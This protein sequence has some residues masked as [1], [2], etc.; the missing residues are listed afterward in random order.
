MITLIPNGVPSTLATEVRESRQLQGRS[1]YGR[2]LGASPRGHRQLPARGR[3][4]QTQ[5]VNGGTLD[6][7]GASTSPLGAAMNSLLRSFGISRR[8]SISLTGALGGRDT[9]RPPTLP[10]ADYCGKP[11]SFGPTL[12][13]R[14]GLR[15]RRARS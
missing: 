7:G 3:R 4:L 10:T 9:F 11:R 1:R 2:N 6:E 15:Y 14:G 8:A 5:P 12:E 13:L